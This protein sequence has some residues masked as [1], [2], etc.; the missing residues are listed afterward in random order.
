MP[1][2]VRAS[3]RGS[4]AM[5]NIVEFSSANIQLFAE[6]TKK[7]IEFASNYLINCFAKS[8]IISIFVM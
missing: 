6:S 4:P 2:N 3:N 8:N 7:I 5:T 1:E